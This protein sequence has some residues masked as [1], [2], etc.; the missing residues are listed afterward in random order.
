MRDNPKHFADIENALTHKSVDEILKEISLGLRLNNINFDD[1]LTKKKTIAIIPPKYE[2]WLYFLLAIRFSHSGYK[3]IFLYHNWSNTLIEQIKPS[4]S[5]L[6]YQNLSTA[7]AEDYSFLK[8]EDVL[9]LNF[10]DSYKGISATVPGF[11]TALVSK[12]SDLDYVMAYILANAFSFAG[13]KK[14]NLKRIIIDEE[15]KAEFE[16]KVYNRLVSV[17]NFNT[18]KITSYRVKTQIHQIVSDAI[19]E[20]ADLILGGDDF[21]KDNYNNVILNNVT[22]DMRVFQKSFFG[23]VLQLIY[24]SFEPKILS[25]VVAQQP[26]RGLVLFT[27]DSKFT[28]LHESCFKDKEYVVRPLNNEGKISGIIEYNP[29]LETMFK[30]LGITGE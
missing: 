14:S 19:S 12:D 7:N 4:L 18:T 20:G 11:S 2:L 28:S 27:N 5:Y 29:S 21:E 8:S 23:P 16:K 24:T 15:I 6:K 10:A 9:I 30:M 1:T 13:M 25:K 22:R 3:V 26:S 17:D